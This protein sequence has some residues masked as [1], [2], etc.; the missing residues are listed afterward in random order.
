MSGSKKPDD[1]FQVFMAEHFNG[2]LPAGEYANL[3]YTKCHP[4]RFDKDNTF[5]IVSTCRDEICNPLYETLKKT[6]GQAFDLSSLAGIV[7]PGATALG[8][9]LSHVPQ[10]HNCCIMAF[11]H[12]GVNQAGTPGL[13]SRERMKEESH[14]CGA[15]AKLLKELQQ[16]EG[17]K[18]IQDDFQSSVIKD[19]LEYSVMRQKLGSDLKNRQPQEKK[20]LDLVSLTKRAAEVANTDLLR[21]VKKAVEDSKRNINYV[22]VVGIQ[23]HGPGYRT[24]VWPY[25]NTIVKGGKE[26][27][28]ELKAASSTSSSSAKK[29]KKKKKKKGKKK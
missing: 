18:G 11:P 24:Y 21:L 26:E 4:H 22:V 7:C 23:V 28:L 9:A 29:K 3:L 6:W 1:R 5:G 14:A 19:D 15:L 27:I 20:N 16:P 17:P 12:I 2:Y 25:A 10:G 8:A 13:V